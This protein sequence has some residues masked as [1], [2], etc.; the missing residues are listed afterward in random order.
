MG[1]ANSHSIA[2][3]IAKALHAQGAQLAFTYQGEALQKRLGPLA[4]SIGSNIILPCDVDKNES[5]SS[6]FKSLREEWDSI[7][8]VVHAIAY[9][10]KEELKGRYIDTS[11]ENFMRTLKISCYSFTE[12]ARMAE[13]LMTSGGSLITLTFSN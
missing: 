9:S 3:G 2:W 11:Y 8:F 13:P 5:I 10:D 12:V 4:T 6:V 1:V 7:D